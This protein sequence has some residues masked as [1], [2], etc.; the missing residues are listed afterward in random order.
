MDFRIFLFAGRV[1]VALAQVGW[2]LHRQIVIQRRMEGRTRRIAFI[3][4]FL[5]SLLTTE[6]ASLRI[7][8]G[9]FGSGKSYISCLLD[10]IEQ[11]CV[12][13]SGSLFSIVDD[14][15]TF[16]EYPSTGD[17]RFQ[18]AAGVPVEAEKIRIQELKIDRHTITNL[19]FLR[20]PPGVRLN[21]TI[22]I[23]V[24]KRKPFSLLFRDEATLNLNGSP[25]GPLLPGLVLSKHGLVTVPIQVSGRKEQALWDTAA[26]LT[27]VDSKYVDARPDAFKFVRTFDNVVDGSDNP[28]SA[29]VYRATELKIGSRKLKNLYVLAV[30][31]STIRKGVSPDLHVVLGFNAI[32][33]LDWYMDLDRKQWSA[34]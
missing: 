19:T 23:N 14:P 29:K 26:E 3:L 32:R 8:K 27:A 16:G 11:N 9:P 6:A 21:T 33:R 17:L 20:A 34:R 10:G 2:T 15:E 30:D 12:I 22:G 28:L 7:V 18:S 25:T 5:G 31:L 24:L 13:D 1:K 4:M